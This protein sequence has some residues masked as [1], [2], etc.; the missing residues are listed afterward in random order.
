MRRGN[1]TGPEVGP[2]VR[3]KLEGA[4]LDY[5]P[6]GLLKVWKRL[7]TDPTAHS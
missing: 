4:E 2:I 3:E 7:V 5:N 1:Q 6:P